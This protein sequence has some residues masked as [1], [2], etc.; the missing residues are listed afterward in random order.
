[1]RVVFLHAFPLDERMWEPQL[2]ALT[3]LDTWAPRL[4]G[5]GP[6]LV[7]WAEQLL[8]ETEGELLA[9][10]ASMGGYTA[11][12]LAR[13]AP[14]RVAGLVLAG[15]RSGPDSPERR[16]SRDELIRTLE[17]SDVP[18]ELETDAS[19]AEL[20]DAARALRDRPDA[21]PVLRS[22]AGP[23]L[24]CVGDRDDLLSVPEARHQAALAPAGRLEVVEGAGHLLTVEQPERFSA[25]L[26]GFLA[27][28]GW[29]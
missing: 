26:L 24:V 22:F 7:A 4:Y 11:L 3:G 16:V 18:A 29:R 15:S 28:S 27:A 17:S 8:A 14:E 13:L 25:I 5:R 1:M 20:A 23:L 19:A 10:G 21:T 9:V 12:Q 2:H 6:S